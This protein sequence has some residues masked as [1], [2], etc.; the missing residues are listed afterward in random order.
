MSISPLF[1]TAIGSMFLVAGTVLL[2]RK[3]LLTGLL[4]LGVWALSMAG[5]VFAWLA[6]YMYFFTEGGNR[7]AP[8]V[9]F[10][11]LFI[12]AS[13]LFLAIALSRAYRNTRVMSSFR[14]ILKSI[15]WLLIYLIVV[16]AV[17]GITIAAAIGSGGLVLVVLWY[18]AALP[19]F[20]PGFF[21][22]AGC[23]YYVLITPSQPAQ[24]QRLVTLSFAAAAVVLPFYEWY[25]L[26][27]LP[28]G[29]QGR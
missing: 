3:R 11:V 21:V 24:R 20:I 1:A 12:L 19:L 28:S 2:L 5:F 16:V 22:G 6:A 10:P 14:N 29:W 23:L 13:L 4:V 26:S 17:H 15:P 8:Y 27:T 18:D 25:L 7:E 9:F